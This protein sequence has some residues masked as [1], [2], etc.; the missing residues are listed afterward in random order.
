MKIF[1]NSSEDRL[2]AGWRI[3]L[4][5]ILMAF[6]VGLGGAAFHYAWPK[7]P[8]AVL[9]V[10]QFIGVIL[11]IYVAATMLD[12]RRM[13]DYG[14][15][16]NRRWW[17]ECFWGMGIAAVAVG[18][19]FFTE[20]VLGWLSITGFGWQAQ[21]TTSFAL[22]LSSS[23][24]AMLMVGFH[25]ELFSRGYQVLNLA[26]GLR[27]PRI[28][29]GGAVTIA[30]LLTST[31][32]GLLH[33]FNPNASAVSTF[34]IVLAGIVLALPYIFTGSLALSVGLHFSWNFVMGGIAGFPVSGMHFE[35][36]LFTIQVQGTAFWTGGAF[37]PEG[38][39]LGLLGMAIML[40]LS[41]VYIK[42]VGYELNIASIFK[43]E[44][45]T[46]LKTDEQGP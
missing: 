31:L 13:A 33:Y 3:F 41:C 36:A 12:K 9:T 23:L 7:A 40:T 2:R 28:G 27:Y 42:R 10:P 46:G 38:G 39:L 25:E 43:K 24:A 14:I 30:V 5:F 8:L 34:N 44:Q 35:A 45:K 1:W 18:F 21:S 22:G 17:I 6:I 15:R 26:E 4:Q 20:W 16:F 19:I 32:F 29:Q 37:G 11:S